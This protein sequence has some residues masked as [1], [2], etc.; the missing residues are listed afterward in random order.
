MTN[1]IIT[2]RLFSIDNNEL[3]HSE[4]V[5]TC[6]A[7]SGPGTRKVRVVWAWLVTKR[8]NNGRV[9]VDAGVIN[10]LFRI[11]Y[12]IQLDQHHL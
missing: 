10:S 9:I 6:R 11:F 12:L 7:A 5:S 3:K 2:D 8:G 4:T 1:V